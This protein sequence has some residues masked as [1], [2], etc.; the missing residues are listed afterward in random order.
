MFLLSQFNSWVLVNC[1]AFLLINKKL[2]S[3]LNT[4]SRRHLFLK[5]WLLNIASPSLTCPDVALHMIMTKD[6]HL[7]GMFL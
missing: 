6:S 1:N 3:N 7:K 2:V 5:K 4:S